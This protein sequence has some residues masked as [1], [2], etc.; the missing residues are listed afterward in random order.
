MQLQL[1][2]PS[3]HVGVPA[4]LPALHEPETGQVLPVQQICPMVPHATQLLPEHIVLP[5]QVLIVTV[6]TV[7]PAVPP[8]PSHAFLSATTLVL[9]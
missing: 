9:Q 8:E 4:Q 7:E 2:C 3:E 1:D 5:L 6:A